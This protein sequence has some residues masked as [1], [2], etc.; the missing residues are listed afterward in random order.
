MHCTLSEEDLLQTHC[1]A[2]TVGKS[3][4]VETGC[5]KIWF[6]KHK[7]YK[8][9]VFKYGGVCVMVETSAMWYSVPPAYQVPWNVYVWCGI[10]AALLSG[11]NQTADTL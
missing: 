7:A 6:K 1:L 9:Y 11:S 8:S 5:N 4:E 10:C 2:C 3:R